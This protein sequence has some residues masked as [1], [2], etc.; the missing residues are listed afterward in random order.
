MKTKT[1]AT[2]MLILTLPTSAMASPHHY[3]P[4]HHRPPHRMEHR[5]RRPMPPML[6]RHSEMPQYENYEDSSTT[7][8]NNETYSYKPDGAGDTFKKAFANA[9]GEA[10]GTVAREILGNVL[11]AMFK[12]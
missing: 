4:H 11:G 10:A 6:P 12:Q 8:N 7:S 2:I 9:A 1:I 5:H 3:G